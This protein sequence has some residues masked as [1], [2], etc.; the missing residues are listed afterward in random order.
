MQRK[1]W[2][3]LTLF[4]GLMTL[5]LVGWPDIS[6]AAIDINA[7][8]PDSSPFTTIEDVIK[9]VFDVT[10]A[11]GAIIFLINFLT[12]GITYLS[13]AGNEETVTKSKKTMTNSIVGLLLTLAAWALANW[14]YGAITSG[15]VGSIGQGGGSGGGST[16]QTPGTG[17]PQDCENLPLPGENCPPS[18]APTTPGGLPSGSGTTSTTPAGGLPSGSGSATP[19]TTPSTGSPSPTASIT[20]AA[21]PSSPSPTLSTGTPTPNQTQTTL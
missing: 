1:Y 3:G 14:I 10:I 7:T 11:I 13:G 9:R 19:S 21:T 16:Q 17:N 18:T 4:L 6:Q 20:P 12:G 8:K 5:I 2:V 15:D